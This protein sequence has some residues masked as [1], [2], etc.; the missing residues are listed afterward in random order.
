MPRISTHRPPTLLTTTLAFLTTTFALT[1]TTQAQTAVF[2]LPSK[3]N[4]SGEY[5]GPSTGRLVVRGKCDDERLWPSI[6]FW[7]YVGRRQICSRHERR[8]L[9]LD[10]ESSLLNGEL[11][12]DYVEADGRSPLEQLRPEYDPK[13]EE[14]FED[15]RQSDFFFTLHRALRLTQGS[16][17]ALS[18]PGSDSSFRPEDLQRLDLK[19]MHRAFSSYR[20]ESVVFVVGKESFGADTFRLKHHDLWSENACACTPAF[21][22]APSRQIVLVDSAVVHNIAELRQSLATL[23]AYYL[24]LAQTAADQGLQIVAFHAMFR[25]CNRFVLVHGKAEDVARLRTFLEKFSPVFTARTES[26]LRLLLERLQGGMIPDAPFDPLL[27]EEELIRELKRPPSTAL[28]PSK[29]LVL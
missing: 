1:Q 17:Y 25:F 13:A 2:F 18:R 24:A 6:F 4:L 20:D 22:A 12:F 21:N 7:D 10:L 11:H 29:I 19:T 27:A 8:R 3:L 9:T 28:K 26:Y 14:P 5:A 23:T 15:Y 16:R